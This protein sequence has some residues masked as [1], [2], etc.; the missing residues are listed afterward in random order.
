MSGTV[1][2]VACDIVR[3]SSPIAKKTRLGM[4]IVPGLT[5]VGAHRLGQ[6]DSQFQFRLIEFATSAQVNTWA[7]LIGALQGTVITIVDDHND[8]YT[9]MLV[10]GVSNPAK[11]AAWVIQGLGT[12]GRRGEITIQGV[13]V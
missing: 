12:S 10:V 3:T 7:G 4:W 1:G 6:N 11:T 13:L 2:G 5:G 8:T 9:G